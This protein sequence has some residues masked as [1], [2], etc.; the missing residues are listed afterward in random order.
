M[1]QEDPLQTELNLPAVEPKVRSGE[2]GWGG[3][4]M[5]QL[6]TPYQE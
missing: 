4:I 6:E 2:C 5:T 3:G 1:A